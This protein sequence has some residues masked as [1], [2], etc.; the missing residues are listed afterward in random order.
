MKD[1][2][3]GKWLRY[4]RKTA[5]L[6]VNDVI[7]K[8]ANEYDIEYTN[9][10]VYG[11]ESGQNQPPADTFLILCKMYNVTNIVESMGYVS[12]N[13]RSPL[14]LTEK[15]EAL[16]E[17]YRSNKKMQAAVDKLLDISEPNE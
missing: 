15:E 10:A 6:S 7:D 1:K 2:S 5:K 11:W 13:G 14:I 8:F 17:Q 16:V 4:Y 12:K 9:K 3:I